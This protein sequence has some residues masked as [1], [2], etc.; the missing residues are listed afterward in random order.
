[1]LPFD[2]LSDHADDEYFADGLTDD[3]I[4]DLSKISGLFMIARN[5]VFAYKDRA[6]DLRE[7]AR[8]LG[9]RYLLEGSVRRAGDQLRINAQ[10]ID[11]ATGDHLWAD[12]F[13][14]D[15]SDIFAVQDE[16]IRHIVDALAIELSAPE[17]HRLA[18]L[19]TTNSSK[20]TITICAP[21]R[22][23]G[24]ASARNCAWR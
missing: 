10:L 22:R 9:V 3:L 8:D 6:A 15:A 5:S 7:V 18:R 20:P 12:R 16:V 4:T 2:N 21:S 24:P 11:G 17:Q 23:H 14:R 13:D 19:P 1:M